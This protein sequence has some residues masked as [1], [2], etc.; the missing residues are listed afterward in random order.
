MLTAKEV[1]YEACKVGQAKVTKPNY[2]VII[3]AILAG[4]F[5]AFGYYGY[6]VLASTASVDMLFF[7]KFLGAFVFPVGLMLILIG[8]GDLFTGNSL[9]TMGYMNKMY[10]FKLVIK[11][12]LLVY[13]G[14]LIGALFF[15]L[16]IYSSN[17]LGESSTELIK[18]LAYQKVNLTFIQAV[19]RGVLCN[20]LVVMAVYMSF[21]AKNITGRVIVLYL[22]ILLFVVS[23]FE[24]SIA[25][26]FIL[27]MAYVVGGDLTILDIFIKNLL[28]VTLG[29]LIAGSILIP[30]AYYLI[31]IKNDK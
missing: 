27:P 4:M 14:N 26:M 25:N 9:V 23:G 7:G 10:K 2:K 17:I 20:V 8:G 13:L 24:H 22:P 28:P 29:N 5:I 18:N 31:F 12:L 19:S 30:G 1:A 21:S 16:L 11:N 15:V 6:I 3:S